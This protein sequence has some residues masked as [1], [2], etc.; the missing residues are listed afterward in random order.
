MATN[1]STRR[2][3]WYACA[4][5][6]ALVCAGPAAGESDHLTGYKVKEAVTPY[7]S[8]HALQDALGSGN[9]TLKKAKF[10]LTGAEKDAGD[11]P[12]GGPAGDYICYTAKCDLPEPVLPLKDD[13]LGPH[14][15][16][17]KKVKIV[18]LPVDRCPGGA[19]VDGV[20]WVKGSSLESCDD[21]CSD[22]GQTCA[23]ETISYAGSGGT[24]AN[25]QAVSDAL[26]GTDTV[27]D[28]APCNGGYGCFTSVGGT[29]RCTAPPTTC[30]AANLTLERLCACQPPIADGCGDGNLDGGEQ[31]DGAD[32]DACPGLC[33]PDCACGLP[34]CQATTGG[35][36]WFLG[37]TGADCDTTCAANGRL[38][39]AATA[40]Y[41]GS[42]G[43]DTQCQAV[44]NDLGLAGGL[45]GNAYCGPVGADSV[46]VGCL[47]MGSDPGPYDRARCVGQPTSSSADW[48]G[49]ARACAC[50]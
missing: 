42:G 15:L 22:I 33:Q 4:A 47:R 40:T 37:A 46:G 25:C 38:Y 26:G 39:D 41:A 2:G 6:A 8:Q 16:T 12:R 50:Q 14:A 9:C 27:T 19:I 20:C 1:S 32:D 29:Q 48:S 34:A 45:T 44:L 35:F 3:A 21:A 11:D 17:A 10:Y 23:P 49:I 43:N 13:Q 36:C 28:N 7:L 18:C 31:C 30:G 5:L 24:L